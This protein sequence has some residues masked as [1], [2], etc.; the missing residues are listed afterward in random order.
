MR[1]NWQTSKLGE[2]VTL[3]RGFDLPKKHRLKGNIPIIS[4]SGVTGWHSESKIMG[5]GVVTGRYGT[6][7]KV[8]YSEDEFWPLNT[9]LFVK[10]F[11]SN[12]PKFIYY[13]LQ[14]INYNS[15]NAKSSVPGINRNDLHEIEIKIP[16]FDEQLEISR[17][18]S[19]LD[20]KIEL[21]NQINDTLEEMAMTLY[22]HWFFDFG[23]FQNDEFVEAE[24]GMIP[25]GWEVKTLGDVS[26]L[27]DSKRVPLSRMEREKRE[28]IFPYYGATSIMDYVDDYIF[29]GTYVLMGEDGS[30]MKD[31]CT[32]YIQYISGKFWVNNHAHILEGKNGI[33][34]E[35]LKTFLETLN[36]SPIVTGAVQPK[37]NQRNLKSV[38]FLVPDDETKDRFNNKLTS[39]FK[40]VLAN[41]KENDYLVKIRDYLLPK[42][43]SGDI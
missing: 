19:D 43:L 4:S 36:V 40:K 28:G 17:F 22:K 13:L 24:L 7:G 1:K 9:T 6:V 3:Q 26:N 41:E 25:K 42:L 15:I 29:D 38:K 8:F 5:P 10:D 2:Q 35:W 34:T 21:N 20:N 16:P 11:K 27:L 33:S 30:V 39:L 37:I 18:L 32:P 12:H 14:T 23:P 31:D